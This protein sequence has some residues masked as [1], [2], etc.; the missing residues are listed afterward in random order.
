MSI[1]K[2]KEKSDFISQFLKEIEKNFPSNNCWC[3]RIKHQI[4]KENHRMHESI[5][6]SSVSFRYIYIFECITSLMIQIKIKTSE[7]ATPLSSLSNFTCNLALKSQLVALC[8]QQKKEEV[9]LNV[10]F[11]FCCF[12]DAFPPQIS[13]YS[14]IKKHFLS[15]VICLSCAE[16]NNWNCSIFS[17]RMIVV[18]DIVALCRWTKK[19]TKIEQTTCY[20]S[21][22]QYLIVWTNIHTYTH[23][24]A[25]WM[26][27]IEFYIIFL[28]NPV[29]HN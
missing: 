1:F 29:G 21:E 25:S 9:F 15:R 3:L 17:E 22:L 13:R 11:F 16:A 10:M 2:T 7:C 27:I 23:T 4:A 12:G 26:I 24:I 19:Q 6:T 20:V 14:L 18:C 8:E 5:F 28:V